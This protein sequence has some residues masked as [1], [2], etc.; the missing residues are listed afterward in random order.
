MGRLGASRVLCGLVLSLTLWAT[1][2]PPPSAPPSQTLLGHPTHLLLPP[3]PPP[4]RGQGHHRV[5]RPGNISQGSGGEEG[6]E[7][8]GRNEGSWHHTNQLGHQSTSHG[9]FLPGAPVVAGL[10]FHSTSSTMIMSL[11]SLKRRACIQFRNRTLGA[12]RMSRRFRVAD[13]VGSLRHRRRLRRRPQSARGHR[14][15]CL[16]ARPR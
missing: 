6:G 12:P 5:P 8:E 1:T 3:P 10:C 13:S 7:G 2:P 14:A 15:F 11:V 4:P 9:D 16:P